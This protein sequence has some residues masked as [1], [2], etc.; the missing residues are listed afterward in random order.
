MAL[1]AIVL[2]LMLGC[3]AKPKVFLPVFLLAA[4]ALV[5]VA[6]GLGD[7]VVSSIHSEG[8]RPAGNAAPVRKAASNRHHSERLRK[9]TAT[10]N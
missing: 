1:G 10:H 5:L 6:Y 3:L 7:R 4:C 2:V 8:S 9:N